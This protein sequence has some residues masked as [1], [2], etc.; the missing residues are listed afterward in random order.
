LGTANFTMQ[1][2]DEG[3]GAYSALELAARQEDLGA[4]IGVGAGLD[5]AAVGLS[6]LSDKLPESLDLLADVLRRPT[7]SPEEMERVRATWI[8]GIKQEKARPQTAAMRIMP[9]LLYGEGHPYAIPFTGSG[10]EASIASLTRDDLVAFHGNWLQP[11]KARVV[12]VGDTTLKQILPLLEQRFG[13]WKTPAGA[14]ALPSVSKV[15]IPAANHVYLINQP[16]ATQ[17]NVYVGQLVPPTGDAGTIDFD[18]ANGVLGGEFTSRLNSNLREDKHWA[19]GSYS[20]A[21]N[22]LG[23]RPWFASAAVQTDKTAE[24]IKEL[25]AEITAFASGQKPATTA[26]IAKIRAS[27]TLSLPGGYETASAVQGQISSNLRYGRPDDYIVQYKARN[28]AMTV[29]EVQAAAKTLVPG[30]LMYVVVGDL[31]K[32]EAPV[33]ALN[34]GEVSVL[35]SDGKPV[36]PAK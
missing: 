14:P 23:Q 35:D 16:G 7:F 25:R 24:S 17:S 1:M 32:V 19:Y 13:D 21:T 31:S 26:E 15:A 22:T 30:S 10:T 12:V 2:L 4:Q 29:A 6:A 34:L 11:D 20:N 27:N 3:A 36:K 8:A 28:D 33:R 18:F 9:P 5:Y